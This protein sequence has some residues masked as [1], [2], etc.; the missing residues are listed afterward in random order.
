VAPLTGSTLFAA[1]ATPATVSVNDANSVELGMRFTVAS[2]GSI[3]GMRF[4]KGPQ[5]VGTHTGTLWTSTGTQLGTV[6]FQNE[7]A[8]GWQSASFSSPIAVTAGTSYVV[9]YHTNSGF[10]SA[11][12]GYFNSATTNGQLTAPQNT[13]GSGNGLFAYGSG[14]IFPTGTYQA[15]NYWVDVYYQQSAN[16]APVAANDTGLGTQR[17]VPLQIAAASLLAN[18]SDANGDSL[19]I[20]GVSGA[21][22][23]T[24]AFDAQNNI[25]TFTPTANYTGNAGFTYAVSDGRGGTASANVALTVSAPPA[26]VS[27]FA[28][29]ATPTTTT[30][31]DPNGV[32][33][34]M[35]FTSSQ[36]GAITGIRFYKGPQNTGTHTGTLWSATGTNLGT[37]TFQNETASG[38]QTA[39]FATPIAITAGTTYVVSYHSNGNYSASGNGFDQAI[40]AGPLTAP[41][42]TS[43]GGNGLYAYGSSSAFPTNSYNASNYYVDVVFNGQLAS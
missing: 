16:I 28:P 30:V 41:S 2:S 25:V 9:S 7:S 1:N 36:D 24:V 23:G 35:K 42:S 15:T 32:E 5:N 21:S 38:W 31:N 20:T 10:Y 43:S 39:S 18:D 17:G 6:T 13:D 37:L 3:T 8:S 26:G 22:N 33:L 34:G 11:T 40:A 14:S 19:G 27:L 29:T 12:S 4:Y